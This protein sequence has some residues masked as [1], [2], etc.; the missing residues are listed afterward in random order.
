MSVY[1]EISIK[2]S[3]E[4]RDILIAEFYNIGYEG[5]WETEDGFY[6]YIQENKFVHIALHNIIEK[7]KIGGELITYSLKNIPAQNW[8]EEWEKNFEPVF[9]ADKFL[10]RAPFHFI[11][12][13]HLA[14]FTISPKMA[15]GTGHHATT[16]LMLEMMLDIEI[17]DKEVLDI[18]TGTGILAII[19]EYLGAKEVMAIDNSP[20]AIH[21][22]LENITINNC[23]KITASVADFED[24]S[25]QTFDVILANINRNTL[26]E[27][28]VY[29]SQMLNPNGILL[30]S[31]FYENDFEYISSIFE[32]ANFS[33]KT[34]KSKNS[35]IACQFIKE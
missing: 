22:T 21:C 7:H 18:G 11:E 35:W 13:P 27:N 26:A 33:F 31:G 20:E 8:N 32:K 24:V 19:A 25:K 29:L 2:C 5:F 17:A 15:F 6:A 4:S 30:L 14:T 34:S 16:Q 23:T 1:T 9:V 10:I 28:A 12:A 3:E